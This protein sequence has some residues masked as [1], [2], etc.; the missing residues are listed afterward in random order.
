MSTSII[1]MVVVLFGALIGAAGQYY[2]KKGANN[3]DKILPNPFKA[4]NKYLVL[5]VFLYVSSA[6]ATIIVLPLGELSVL[7][8]LVATNFIWVTLIAKIKLKE[9][10]NKWKIMGVGLILI[11]VVLTSIGS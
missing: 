8:P 9:K 10:I 11:G 1:A 4:I 7:Y 6:I 5:A 3:I 2:F